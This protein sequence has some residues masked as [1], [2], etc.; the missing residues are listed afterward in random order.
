MLDKPFRALEPSPAS[1]HSDSRSLS[2]SPATAQPKFPY[3]M[4]R[5][6]AS[7]MARS[8]APLSPDLPSNMDC[9]FP[10]F[11][12]KNASAQKARSQTR[13][14]LEPTFSP[15][16]AQPNPLFAPLSP[17]IN[18]GENITR[19][20]DSIAS[21]PFDGRID[22]RPSTSH[23]PMAPVQKDP[24]ISHRR[25]GSQDSTRSK[26]GTQ[27]QRKSWKSMASR[28]STY[29][30]QSNVTHRTE[31]GNYPS[32]I[33]SDSGHNEGIDA[34]LHRLQNESTN[35]S[36][37][38]LDKRSNTY[39][40]RQIDD[41]GQEPT[42]R[43][44]M[45]LERSY[46]SNDFTG[47]N[48]TFPTRKSSLSSRAINGQHD[49]SR[50]QP[51]QAYQPYQRAP[52]VVPTFSTDAPLNPLHTPSDS[53]LSDDSYASSSFRS[54]ASS[55]SSPPGSVIGHSREISKMSQFDDFSEEPFDRTASPDS[56][57]N[58]QSANGNASYG[59]SNGQQRGFQSFSSGYSDMP[60]SPMDPAIQFGSSFNQRPTPAKERSPPRQPYGTASRQPD[61][62][63]SKG[64]NKGNCRGCSDVI[65]GKSVK[66]SSGRLTG[67]YH[68]Q[69]F[70]CRTCG[71]PFPTAEF[72]V[73]E[74]F[75]YCEQHY[76]K[77]NGTLCTSCDRGIEGQYLETDMRQ[78]F[79]PRCF[80]CT[81]CRVVLRDDYYE[82]GGQRFCD[83]HAQ[84]AA[85]PP[86][87]YLGPGGYKPR[88]VQKRR[89][90][91]MM[92]A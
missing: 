54:N 47:S 68:K 61:G 44:G 87:N 22:R 38:G 56:Y 84:Y 3:R 31:V 75:P 83:R 63:Q 72:Y 13:D 26:D 24:A 64:A 86:Q 74:N 57:T 71:D 28:S 17:R 14:R 46:T 37:P 34:F 12:T 25:M 82:V 49:T 76:H 59:T 66:D 5:S 1:S 23:A 8:P 78:K 40:T 62:R 48:N 67:R 18:G 90:R 19:R 11:P 39:P 10:P 91:L 20:M 88:N 80:T 52:L 7:P 43:P 92:M 4:N 58:H 70:A 65:I 73:F 21:G 42:P 50:Y 51:Y 79:H 45:P 30:S 2:P 69:C 9:A 55:R 16:S 33:L 60:E 15:R 6:I 85:A 27:K 89:T 77:L 29:S 53:G 36:R 35:P 41:E 81:T 32:P